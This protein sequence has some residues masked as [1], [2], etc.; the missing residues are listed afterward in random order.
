MRQIYNDRLQ[1]QKKRFS[2]KGRLMNK[3]KRELSLFAW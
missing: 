1:D 3:R 2:K